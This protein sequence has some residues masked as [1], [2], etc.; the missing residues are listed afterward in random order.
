[1]GALNGAAMY[2]GVRGIMDARKE[3]REEDAF[4]T[5]Q[6]IRK[7]RLEQE[8]EERPLRRRALEL[9]VQDAEHTIGRRPAVE[10]QQDALSQLNIDTAK[11]T[12]EDRQRAS[13]EAEEAQ[14]RQKV[15]RGGLA[16][17]TASADPKHVADALGQIY[18]EH[19]NGVQ[20][21]RNDDGSITLAMPGSD[22]PM[23]FKGKKWE[24]G[25]VMTPDDEMSM[26]AYNV[27]DPVKS[28][29]KKWEHARKV[30]IEGEKTERALSVAGVRA[31]GAAARSGE[32]RSEAWFGSQHRQ[33]KPVLDS[34]LKTT[35]TAGSFIAGYAHE[36]DAALRGLIE[37]NVES[38][39]ENGTP[40]R[41]AAN[42][43]INDVRE[44]YDLLDKKARQHASALA[45]KKVKP[46]DR[47]A[48][49]AAAAGGDTDA[50]ELLRT[51][52]VAQKRLGSSVAKYLEGQLPTK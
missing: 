44:G 49:E 18:P 14:Q 48:V 13:K 32:R 17:F 7:Q 35:G 26:F 33:I 27:L 43:V 28:F 38:E 46:T 34:V 1:M 2:G 6:A 10:A 30:D 11:L 37:Q 16:K 12:L 39:I 20:A 51:L 23:Q 22:K 52:G 31:D 47:K 19:F 9:G 50:T 24:D 40:V 45:K 3:G 5:D 8:G 25:S 21:N 36:N 15:L 4:D 29:E 42:K 41:A